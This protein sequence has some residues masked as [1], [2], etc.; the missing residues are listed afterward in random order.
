MRLRLLVADSE[1]ADARDQRRQSAGASA[2]DAFA[3][4]VTELAPDAAVEQALPADEDAPA[5]TPPDLV[6]FDAVFLTGS[7][8]HV[9]DDSTAARREIAFMQAVF[10]SHTP[11]FGSCA[12]LQVAVAAAGGTVRSMAHRRESGFA[13]N[14]WLTPEGAAHPLLRGRPPAY[15]A[16][17]VHGDE[18]ERLPPGATLLAGNSAAAVQAVEIRHDGGIFWGVQYHPELSL[19]DLAAATRR[20]AA[21]LIKQGLARDEAD[22]EAQ[23][24]LIDALAGE[25]GRADLAWRL[26][27]D[28]QVTDR[29]LRRRE[30]RNFLDML[31]IPTAERRRG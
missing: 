25:P 12:G 20:D 26:G 24:A 5:M 4:V 15:T 14:I 29:D 19:A 7:P 30:L 27:V 13:R 9:Y 2:G 8:M 17:T 23:A 22:A 6:A 31:V 3:A 1:T 10:A 28:E 18:V 21:T 16:I 11:S